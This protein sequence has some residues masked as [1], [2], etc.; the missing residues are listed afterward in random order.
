MQGEIWCTIISS[1]V[2]PKKFNYYKPDEIG[3][4]LRLQC[5]VIVRVSII[6]M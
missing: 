2:E 6:N 4:K 3:Q 5:F 1:L